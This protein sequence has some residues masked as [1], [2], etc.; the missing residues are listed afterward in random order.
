MLKRFLL[1][2]TVLLLAACEAADPQ[3][4][5][6]DPTVA[7]NRPT[8]QPEMKSVAQE[9][10]FVGVVTARHS[11]IVPVPYRGRVEKLAIRPG[12]KIKAGDP[13]VKLEETDLKNQIE[14]AKM[15]EKSALASAGASGALAAQARKEIKA[16]EKMLKFGAG[17]RMTISQTQAQLQSQSAQAGAAAAQGEQQRF[18]RK[19]LER[20]LEN[21]LTVAKKDGVVMAVKVK[22]GEIAEEGAQ[23]ARIC[24]DSDLMIKFAVPKEQKNRVR[25]GG[26]VE[27]H[28]EGT[29]RTM[30]A[31]IESI[32]VEEAPINLT[33]V[34]AD[35]DDRKLMPD[36]VT[37]SSIAK[38]KL[39]ESPERASSRAS[40]PRKEKR[41]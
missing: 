17:T 6:P 10:E 29:E 22:E 27:V 26:K 7:V 36:E 24:D 37:V 23:V 9:I 35:L 11:E 21:A 1:L 40:K 20:R 28:I 33:V 38:V 25:K 13:I 5:G 19:Q 39:V 30:F 15:A 32:S 2:P 34:V 12:M 41:T 8:A 3:P 14:A 18:S 4:V 16:Q 31:T